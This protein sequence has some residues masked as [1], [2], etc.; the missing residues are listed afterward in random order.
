[1]DL[2]GRSNQPVSQAKVNIDL[3]AQFSVVRELGSA[4]SDQAS[5][6]IYHDP[7]RY[8]SKPTRRGRVFQTP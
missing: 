8:S 7:I 2:P 1:M 6:I 4:G 3:R 5:R